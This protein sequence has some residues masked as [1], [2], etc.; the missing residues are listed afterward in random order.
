[1]AEIKPAT[2][3]VIKFL[4]EHDGNY[5]AQDVADALG[6]EDKRKVDGIFTSAIQ[7]KDL[8]FRQ[9]GEEED[10]ETGLHKQIK[11]LKLNDAGKALDVDA[12]DEAE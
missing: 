2:K 6:I 4:Q 5:T 8:G 7:R 9:V 12:A 11:F 1:M 3:Q 10:P